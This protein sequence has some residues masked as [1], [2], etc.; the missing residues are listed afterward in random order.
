MMVVYEVISCCHCRFVIIEF[1]D[2]HCL[3]LTDII[4]FYLIY[5]M[6]TLLLVGIQYE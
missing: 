4:S 5:S 1:A 2:T 3:S 6:V